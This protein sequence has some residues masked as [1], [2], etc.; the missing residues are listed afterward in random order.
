[1][2]FL[3]NFLNHEVFEHGHIVDSSIFSQKKIH[4]W[5]YLLAVTRSL[6]GCHLIAIS[7][8]RLILEKFYPK[9]ICQVQ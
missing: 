9:L 2:I 6:Y 7:T 4:I 5:T 8:Y 1:M 3:I